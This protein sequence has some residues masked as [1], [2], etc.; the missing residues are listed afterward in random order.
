[1][2][3]ATTLAVVHASGLADQDKRKICR[4]LALLDKSSLQMTD[5]ELV[6][7]REAA[8]LTRTQAARLFAVKVG[9]PIDSTWLRMIEHDWRPD[10]TSTLHERFAQAFDEIYGLGQDGKPL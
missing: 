7:A 8:G 2:S 5:S 1:M 6:A 3:L 10:P 4:L 9:M